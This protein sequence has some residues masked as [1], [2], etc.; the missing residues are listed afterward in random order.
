MTWCGTRSSGSG[1]EL[2]ERGL[3]GP[4]ARLIGSDLDPKAL[5]T[6]EAN[7]KSAGLERFE[8][9]AADATTFK[10]EGVTLIV[11]NPPMGRRVQRG[12]VAPLLDRL[13]G[14]RGGAVAARRAS[15]VDLPAAARHPAGGSRCGAWCAAGPSRSTWAASPASSRCGSGPR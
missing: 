3:L 7:L 6:A 10:P 11:T 14:E 1:L 4:Y 12:D 2:V 13:P 9:H 15:G 8:L 5:T